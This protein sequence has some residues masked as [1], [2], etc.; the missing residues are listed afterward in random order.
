[1]LGNG[2]SGVLCSRFNHEDLGLPTRKQTAHPAFMCGVRT[3]NYFHA[4]TAEN[5]HSYIRTSLELS[6]GAI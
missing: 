6:F 3:R 5:A 2:V 1:M 4:T